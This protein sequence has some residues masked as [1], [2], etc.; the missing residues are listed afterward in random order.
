MKPS[1]K[2]HYILARVV[3]LYRLL[4][5]GKPVLVVCVVHAGRLHVVLLVDDVVPGPD[6]HQVGVVGGGGD[7]DTPG[8]SG[9]GVAQL[10]SQ[11]LELISAEAVVVPET[12]VVARPRGALDA[13][14]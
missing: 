14:V 11:L 8:A 4:D 7:G 2:I 3:D 10:V 5:A 9:V 6:G 13:L 1:C 12:A